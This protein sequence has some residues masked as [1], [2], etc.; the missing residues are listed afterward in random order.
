MRRVTTC[1]A[2]G[3]S[4]VNGGCRVGFLLFCSKI[5]VDIDVKSRFLVLLP[6]SQAKLAFERRKRPAFL[7]F[8]YG[9]IF[10]SG[11]KCAIRPIATLNEFSEGGFVVFLAASQ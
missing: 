11:G 3:S 10:K 2:V 4:S 8:G 6:I 9:Q 7:N 1:V 5:A